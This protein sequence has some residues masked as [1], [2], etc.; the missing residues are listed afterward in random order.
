MLGEGRFL[1]YTAPFLEAQPSSRRWK[2]TC[3]HLRE[4]YGKLIHLYTQLLMTKLDFH[5]RNPRFPGNLQVTKEELQDIGEN[6]INN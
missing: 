3:V 1:T 5:R 6:D 4:G 2:S